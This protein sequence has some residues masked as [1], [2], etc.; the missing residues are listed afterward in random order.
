MKRYFENL[1]HI[2]LKRV[3]IVVVFLKENS[4]IS[5][6]VSIALVIM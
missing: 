6:L 5:L 2:V 1:E 4:F 3:G